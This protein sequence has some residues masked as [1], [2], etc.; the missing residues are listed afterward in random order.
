MP[1]SDPHVQG[2]AGDGIAHSFSDKCKLLAPFVLTLYI[3][4]HAIYSTISFLGLSTKQKCQIFMLSRGNSASYFGL[5]HVLSS[6][7]EIFA[8]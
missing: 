8:A 4:T 6:K 1:S 3:H 5:T 2:Q 7:T